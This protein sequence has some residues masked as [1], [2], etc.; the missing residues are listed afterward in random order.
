MSLPPLPPGIAPI[1][2]LF[3]DAEMSEWLSSG[4]LYRTIRAT[5]EN[6]TDRFTVPATLQLHCDNP[7]CGKTQLWETPGDRTKRPSLMGSEPIFLN[8]T[9]HCW[10]CRYS[11]I[12]YILRYARNGNAVELTKVGQW[13]PLSRELDPVVVD[14]WSQHD[15]N[16]YR[17]AAT[18]RNSNK[19][20]G[21]LPYLRRIIERRI[22]DVLALIA[23]SHGR[24]P[25]PGFDVARLEAVRTS[26]RF[27]E[28]LDVARDFLP[29]GIVVYG[30]PNPIELLY[31]LISDGIHER[32]EEECVAVFDR[33]KN[34]FE[35]VVKKLTE[36][37]RDDEAYKASI[38]GLSKSK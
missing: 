17:D 30:L 28:K 37:K 33:C 12:N 21:A 11:Q 20:I 23:D 26:H 18:F 8:I 3:T 19:G 10:N 5:I 2:E 9:Y 24:Q 36:A 14:G 13:P 32:T 27:S 1:S 15:K 38:Q 29:P 35:F 31:D 16:M 34:A 25:I 6:Q 4:P 7:K 22:G